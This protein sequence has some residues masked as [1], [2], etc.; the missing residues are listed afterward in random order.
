MSAC[1]TKSNK[2]KRLDS[3]LLKLS[4]VSTK[5]RKFGTLRNTTICVKLEAKRL[6]LKDMFRTNMSFW[7]GMANSHICPGQI[8]QS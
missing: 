2:F 5:S 4:Y 1:I 6:P 8:S 7:K 3:E